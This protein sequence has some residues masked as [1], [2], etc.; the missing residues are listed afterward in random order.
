[1]ELRGPVEGG[2][3]GGEARERAEEVKGE[4]LLV[5]RR[6]APDLD[7]LAHGDSE[8]LAVGAEADGRGRA[9]EGDPVEDRAAVEVGVERAALA[10]GDGSV[11]LRRGAPDRGAASDSAGRSVV[12]FCSPTR[13]TDMPPT[14]ANRDTTHVHLAADGR[15]PPRFLFFLI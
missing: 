12:A 15:G 9:L 5:E 11:G 2:D 7:D 10:D 4:E 14:T 13:A 6:R 3:A 1:L 8:E